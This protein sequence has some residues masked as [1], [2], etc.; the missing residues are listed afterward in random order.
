MAKWHMKLTLYFK[1]LNSSEI[2]AE[3]ESQ[4]ASHLIT[5]Q[6]NFMIREIYVAFTVLTGTEV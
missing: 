2:N 3:T 1:L 4:I 5:N 6:H